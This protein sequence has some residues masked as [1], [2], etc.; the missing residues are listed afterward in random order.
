MIALQ[1]MILETHSLVPQMKNMFLGLTVILISGCLAAAPATRPATRPVAIAAFRG[2]GGLTGD[3][4]KIAPPP[5]KLRWTYQTGDE[6]QRSSVESAA[7]I[8]ADTAY[9]ADD[10]G[11]LHAIDLITGKAKWKY[12][13]NIGWKLSLRRRTF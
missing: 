1:L 7:T 3:A 10:R 11:T 12:D 8:T 2:G 5:M 6:K 4:E 9:V 13:A